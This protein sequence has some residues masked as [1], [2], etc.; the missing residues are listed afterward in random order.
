MNAHQIDDKARSRKLM[1]SATMVLVA[2]VILGGFFYLQRQAGSVDSAPLP[3][4]AEEAFKADATKRG[5]IY[6]SKTKSAKWPDLSPGQQE[7]TVKKLKLIRQKWRTWA[8]RN[9]SA[10]KAMLRAQPNDEATLRAVYKGLP[11]SEAARGI[12]NRDLIPTNDFRAALKARIPLLSWNPVEKGAVI[13]EKLRAQHEKSQHSR[14]VIM[15]KDFAQM[16]DICISQSVT[17]PDPSF[18]L[19]ASGRITQSRRVNRRWEEVRNGR[20][21]KISSLEDGPHEE[22]VPP[23]EFLQ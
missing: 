19:W 17:Q 5:M 11:V 13:P 6:D 3:A 8:E 22:I 18:A 10:L 1:M 16:R 15:K 20:K 21:V 14:W 9:Q 23:F 4:T 7:V 12:P 2:A